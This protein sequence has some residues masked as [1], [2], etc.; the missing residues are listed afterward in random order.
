M[1]FLLDSAKA[2]LR[3]LLLDMAVVALSGAPGFVDVAVSVL[4]SGMRRR[5]A[6]PSEAGPKVTDSPHSTPR[7]TTL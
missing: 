5:Q 7:H 2:P 1:M 6:L 4:A 3:K